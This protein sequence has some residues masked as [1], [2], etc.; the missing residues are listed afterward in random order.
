MESNRQLNKIRA[1]F[2]RKKKKRVPESRFECSSTTHTHIGRVIKCRS[3]TNRRWVG[4]KIITA[5]CCLPI[6][7]PDEIGPQW[8]GPSLFCDHRRRPWA[9]DTL[10]HR[11]AA[12]VAAAA[13]A[14]GETRDEQGTRAAVVPL[15]EVGRA[16]LLQRSSSTSS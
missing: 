9:F 10:R 6:T 15:Q 12:A 8:P 16:K 3:S 11:T 4:C 5:F 1:F 7:P 2:Q 13:V 14:T